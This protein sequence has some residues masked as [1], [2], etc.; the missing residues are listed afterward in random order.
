MLGTFWL[1]QCVPEPDRE[2]LAVVT[3]LPLS[4]WGALPEFLRHTGRLH[5]ELASSHG[6]VGYRLQLRLWPLELWT[7]S[8]W[9]DEAALWS[10]VHGKA[11]AN[12]MRELLPDTG[13]TKIAHWTVRGFNV[14]TSWRDVRLKMAT[15]RAAPGTAE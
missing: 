1:A 4:R 10:F 8:V 2:Y 6:L 14:P 12:A 7:F 3:H 13:R 9:V 5:G 11:H 15:H